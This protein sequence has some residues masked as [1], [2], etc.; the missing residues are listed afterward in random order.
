MIPY[1]VILGVSGFYWATLPLMLLL[2]MHAG[3][4]IRLEGEERMKIH[5]RETMGRGLPSL[6]TS[7]LI[8]ISVAFF[9]S[10][11]TQTAAQRQQLPESAKTFIAKTITTF[12]GDQVNELPPEQQGDALKQVTDEVLAK[13]NAFLRPYF[14]YLPP[15]LAFGLFLVL[16]GLS[17]IV[18]WLAALVALGLFAVLKRSGFV[19]IRLVPKEAEELEF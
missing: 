5:I 10:P 2:Q 1:F 14:K 19:R 11:A 4:G 12:L 15:I 13:I 17:F 16:Q 8:M 6:I 7:V 3:H 18:V 9:L